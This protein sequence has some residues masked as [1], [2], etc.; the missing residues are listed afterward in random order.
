MNKKYDALVLLGGGNI[1]KNNGKWRTTNL[2]EGDILGIAGGRIRVVA[3]QLLFN[4]GASNL[5]IASGG[6]GQ[7]KNVAGVP[8]LSRV[9]KNE[10][11]EL[12]V[13]ANNILEDRKSDNT[14]EQ[15][16][17][18]KLLTG[19]RQMKKI[20]IVSNEWHLPRIK[21]MI[22]H[23]PNLTGLTGCVKLIAAEKV[24]I[25]H[26]KLNW[27]DKIAKVRKSEGLKKRVA[28]EKKGVEDI[29]NGKYD[30]K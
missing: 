3:G 4:S 28:L 17:F 11:V 26:G 12:G 1:K 2:D 18:V 5:I 20:A 29:K 13:P 8:T 9:I 23:S 25:K 22:E 24:V 7:Y 6:R 21:A 10:L 16:K 15:L 27:Q 19:S 30:F 14:H